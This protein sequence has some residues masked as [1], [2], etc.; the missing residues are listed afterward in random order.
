MAA[1]LIVEQPAAELDTVTEVLTAVFAEVKAAVLAERPVVVLV[2][3]LLGQGDVV[4]ASVAAG[5]LG[6]VRAFA[7]EGAKPGWR[8]NAVSHRREDDAAASRDAAEWLAGSDL[9]GQLIR[10]GTAHLG[11]VWP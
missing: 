5:L 10:V 4:D 7:L 1:P 3:D 11:K 2:E 9:S 8:V 6:L